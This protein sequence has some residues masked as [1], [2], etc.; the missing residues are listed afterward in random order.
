MVIR[1][2]I[3]FL[4]MTLTVM[5]VIICSLFVL[6]EELSTVSGTVN[7]EGVRL[8]VI[9]YH[10]LTQ[11]SERAGAYTLTQEQFRLDMEYLKERGYEAVDT[12]MLTDYVEGKGDL[13]LKP[14]MIT[15]DD[16][17]ESFYVIAK[18]IL[19]QLDLKAAV[20]VIGYL[21][22][23]YT[24]L[25]DH[26]INYS[27]LTWDEIRELDES[28]LIEVQCHTYNM[29]N[30]VKGKRKGIAQLKGESVQNY[31]KI[32]TDDL[33]TMKRKLAE[34]AGVACEAI[35]YPYGAYSKATAKIMKSFGY[36]LTFTCEERIN[37]IIKGDSDCLFNLGRYNRPSGKS[38]EEFFGKILK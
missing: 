15:F 2:N 8:P 32:I 37:N 6:P 38:S 12:T 5:G 13:P 25:N 21:A 3:K 7:T 28:P 31:E 11:S 10:H 16:G 24:Q 33:R 18:P 23:E 17:F 20:F 34:N 4:I 9:M 26:N 19:E 1:L 29:H 36:K 35:A 22:D 14:V 27:Y 30:N